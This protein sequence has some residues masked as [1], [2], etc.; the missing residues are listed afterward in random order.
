MIKSVKFSGLFLLLVFVAVSGSGCDAL[1]RLLHKEGAEEKELL[2]EVL[3]IESN[4]S[5]EE[6]QKLLKLFGYRPGEIDGKLGP[7]TREA[8]EK[9]QMDHSL[10][11]TR[12]VDRETW[13]KLNVFAESGM[14]VQ[15]EVN[16]LGVQKALMNARFDP[17]ATDGKM[18]PR[19]LQAIKKF[20]RF[21]GLAADGLLG[22]KTLINL[23]PYAPSE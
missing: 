5:V 9:F 21:T 14:V 16:V 3:P 22:Y 7:N 17:G 6:V 4:S 10:K 20:Q 15:G 13:T 19:T 2:G 18:G 8:L 23:V 12:L 1:Y 11:T